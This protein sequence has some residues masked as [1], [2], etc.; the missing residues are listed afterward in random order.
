MSRSRYD[1]GGSLMPGVT[2]A[3]NATR[4]PERV[5]TAAELEDRVLEGLIYVAQRYGRGQAGW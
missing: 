4:E 2:V 3:Y 5:L 1:N